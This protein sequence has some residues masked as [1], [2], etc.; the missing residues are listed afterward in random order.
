MIADV[1]IDVEEVRKDIVDYGNKGDVQS[2]D[3]QCSYGEIDDGAELY[4]VEYFAT[5]ENSEEEANVNGVEDGD[6]Q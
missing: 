6:V 2:D 4:G 3:D 1:V 5:I